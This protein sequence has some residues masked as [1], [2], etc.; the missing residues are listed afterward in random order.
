VIDIVWKL[1]RNSARVCALWIVRP[2]SI[3]GNEWTDFWEGRGPAFQ[4]RPLDFDHHRAIVFG[5]VIHRPPTVLSEEW[6]RF[7]STRT[8]MHPGLTM[9]DN[10]EADRRWPWSRKD[11]RRAGH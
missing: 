6:D 10:R 8:T 9:D 5:A 3:T 4:R 11:L 2:P 1:T 7:W